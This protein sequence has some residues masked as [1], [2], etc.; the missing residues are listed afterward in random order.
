MTD[1]ERLAWERNNEKA[2]VEKVAVKV[3]YEDRPENADRF[4]PM[5]VKNRY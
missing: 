2:H 4:M 3:V 5:C 1:T